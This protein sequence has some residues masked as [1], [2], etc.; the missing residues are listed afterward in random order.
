MPINWFF[1]SSLTLSITTLFLIIILL[2]FGKEK[3]HKMLFFFSL[4]I[5]IWGSGATFVSKITNPLLSNFL[6]RVSCFGV[7]FIPVFLLHL[8]SILT[9]EKIKKIK[10]LAYTQAL[11][12]GSIILLTELIIK[13]QSHDYY[14]NFWIPLPGVLFLAWFSFWL[15]TST[16]AHLQ[17]IKF[18][19]KNKYQIELKYFI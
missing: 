11:F 13:Y 16:L 14:K 7:T 6:Y 15:L 18:Y 8:G 19:L 4:S 3:I 12:F 9:K 17:L 2:K 10:I 1:L 5:F